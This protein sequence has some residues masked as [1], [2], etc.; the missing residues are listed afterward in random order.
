MTRIDAYDREKAVE[1]AHTWAYGRNPAY[2]DFS[3]LGGDCTNFASQVLFA[4]AGVMNY[5][6]ETGWFYTN[7][8]NR[9]PS[10]TGVPYFYNFV[11]SNKGPGPFGEEVELSRIEP[12]DFI[13]FTPDGGRYTHT[14]AV[15][16]AGRPATL[17]SVRVAAHSFDADDRS[18]HSYTIKAMRCIHI[19]GC[20]KG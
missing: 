5:T 7:A 12:G 19:L 15:V 17:D 8:N 1:Y 3:K 11:T 2:Y 14:L 20:R 16:T 4:G 18:L 13:Q 10:W 6:P 9:T